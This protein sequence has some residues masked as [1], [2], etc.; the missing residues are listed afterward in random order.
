[1][2][3]HAMFE[4]L[5]IFRLKVFCA[6]AE[7]R[8][9]HAASERLNISQ[10]TVSFHIGR[11][12]KQTKLVLFERGRV[13]KLTEAGEYIYVYAK[14]V[15]QL[16]DEAA[17]NMQE[18]LNGNSGRITYGANSSLIRYMINYL[19][20]GFIK[21]HP[22]VKFS[23]VVAAP[24]AICELVLNRQITFGIIVGGTDHPELDS[25]PLSRDDIVIVAG[26]GHPLA[27]QEIITVQDISNFDFILTGNSPPYFK[28]IKYV[29]NKCGISV[30]ETRIRIDSMD[31]I[32]QTLKAG[33][34]VSAL[35]RQC[36]DDDL[37]A[38]ALQELKLEGISLSI[39][40]S[41]IIRRDTF[42][43]PLSKEFLHYI[44][45]AAKEPAEWANFKGRL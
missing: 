14:K 24:S 32:K 20:S 15:L 21:T 26:A 31:G 33:Q 34:G 2:E 9:F 10:P 12:E 25:T 19:N 4:D 37:K 18:L 40:I 28:G 39:E 35:L 11:I 13:N 43:S 22:K 5:S 27:K 45:T 17:D 6:V 1:M 16:T 42:V 3:G 36:V 38:K 23:M 29:L 8:S 41:Y 30:N 44:K 7:T